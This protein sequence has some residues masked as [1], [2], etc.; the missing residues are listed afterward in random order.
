MFT[1]SR[2]NPVVP[3]VKL[4][5]TGATRDALQVCSQ[6]RVALLNVWD[7][8]GSAVLCW[9]RL[10]HGKHRASLFLMAAETGRAEHHTSLEPLQKLRRDLNQFVEGF[11]TANVPELDAVCLCKRVMCQERVKLA[12]HQVQVLRARCCH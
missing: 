2:L 10:P 11:K 3:N 1:P 8:S 4:G 5:T 7:S 12:N 6:S 9:E